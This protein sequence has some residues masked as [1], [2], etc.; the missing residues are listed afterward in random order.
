MF[1]N[2]QGINF[3]YYGDILLWKWP[4]VR[5]GAPKFFSKFHS[6]DFKSLPEYWAHSGKMEYLASKSYDG[7][8]ILGFS[9]IEILNDWVS[10]HFCTEHVVLVREL[11]VSAKD[12][13]FWMRIPKDK[14]KNLVKDIVV[15]KCK[16]KTEVFNMMETLDKNFCLAY[17]Y[18]LGKFVG[19]NLIENEILV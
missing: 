13:S 9:Y 8:K 19:T 4:W 6:K 1:L 15:L 11:D 5:Q 16:D 17:G 14:V 7:I 3:K 18:S 12:V 10:I 2:K